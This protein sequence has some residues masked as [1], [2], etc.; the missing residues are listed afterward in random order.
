MQKVH[1]L[2]ELNQM[3]PEGLTIFNQRKDQTG[4]SSVH[5]NVTLIKEY[6][7]KIRKNP[8]AWEFF[9]QLPPSYKRDSI[10]W[11]MSAKKE[12]TQIRRLNRFI[13]SWEKGEILRL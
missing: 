2:I 11:I 9:N 4:Y 6:E 10:W 1:K 3:R 5:R 8:S 12:E 7:D 13:T